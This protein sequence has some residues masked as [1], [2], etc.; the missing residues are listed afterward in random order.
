V[1][2]PINGARVTF[3][4]RQ[5]ASPLP[6]VMDPDQAALAADLLHAEAVLPIHYGGYDAPGLYEPV[7]DPLDRLRAACDRVRAPALGEPI[8]V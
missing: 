3:P 1:C 6:A 2:A 7:A 8:T 5:P 4:H